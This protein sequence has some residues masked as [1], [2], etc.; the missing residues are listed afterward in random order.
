V[1]DEGFWRF[2]YERQR[3]WFM[4]VVLGM[5]APWTTDEVLA[6]FRFCNVHRELDRGTQLLINR[7]NENARATLDVRVM[8]VLL[9]R[10]FNR[11]D[12]P[13]VKSREEGVEMIRE[14]LLRTDR[15][16]FSNTWIPM[17]GCSLRPF[18]E[19]LLESITAWDPGEL[20]RV[21]YEASSLA[22]VYRRVVKLPSIG[23][24]IGWQQTLDLTYV[25]PHL[26]DDEWVPEAKKLG[27]PHKPQTHG[28][29]LAASRIAE[30]TFSSIVHRLRDEQDERL[31]NI[32]VSW[33][34]VAWDAK[35]RLTLGDIEHSLCEYQR[36]VS[37]GAGKGRRRRYP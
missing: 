27:G 21:A 31:A 11:A 18:R 5:A 22:D 29:A 33:A 24:V 19:V 8:N 20:V 6:K 4:R 28:P 32:G 10:Y 7:L 16:V 9:Y 13:W 25:F 1:N 30:G 15:G 2:C 17:G 26:T 34:D 36:Y 35:P 37:I 23:P 12:I 14:R 3:I